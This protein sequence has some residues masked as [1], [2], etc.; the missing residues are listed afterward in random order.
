MS[1]DFSLAARTNQRQ[2]VSKWNLVCRRTEFVHVDSNKD[3]GETALRVQGDKVNMGP[4][5][6][7]KY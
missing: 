7:E 5:E 2:E 4:Q 1:L 3:E 6:N